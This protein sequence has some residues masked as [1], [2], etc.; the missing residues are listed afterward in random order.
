MVPSAAVAPRLGGVADS[1]SQKVQHRFDSTSISKTVH[2]ENSS[3]L[4]CRRRPKP[5]S[6]EFFCVNRRC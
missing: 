2:T 5:K 6:E 4:S 3:D 1:G